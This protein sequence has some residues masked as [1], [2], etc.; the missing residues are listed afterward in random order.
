VDIGT[1]TY[2]SMWTGATLLFMGH[3]AW[4]EVSI[5]FKHRIIRSIAP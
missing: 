5:I 4:F 1:S 3:S 2:E